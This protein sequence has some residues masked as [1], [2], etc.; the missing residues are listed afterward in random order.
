MGYA[1]VGAG[2]RIG[3]GAG[4]VAIVSDVPVGTVVAGADAGVVAGFNSVGVCGTWMTMYWSRW[5][6]VL[7]VSPV[8]LVL[9]SA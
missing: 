6:L 7:L 5:S 8:V 1:T 3:G 2:R 9:A 4:V